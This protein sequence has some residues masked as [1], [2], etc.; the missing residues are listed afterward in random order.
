MDS[1]TWVI[2]GT[3]GTL[4]VGIGGLILATVRGTRGKVGRLAD[5]LRKLAS[6][7]EKLA[8]QLADV[9][10]RLGRMEGLMDGWRGLYPV[11][12]EVSERPVPSYTEPI[13]EGSGEA[14]T[15]P[16]APKP[17]PRGLPEGP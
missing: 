10:E 8:D 16:E 7:G 3:L 9:R 13:P 15:A 4:I 14:R 17:T 11:R 1:E 5:D 12:L 6:S 2:L